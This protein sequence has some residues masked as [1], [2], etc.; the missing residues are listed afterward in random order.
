M[1]K[2]N[3]Y[4]DLFNDYLLCAA[5]GEYLKDHLDRQR[6]L[7]GPGE[8][9]LRSGSLWRMGDPLPKYIKPPEKVDATDP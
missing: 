6:C 7:F 3:E 5:C 8:F 1:A 4:E 2:R 9:M